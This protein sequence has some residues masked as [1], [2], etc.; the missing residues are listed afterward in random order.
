MLR[1]L[2]GGAGWEEAGDIKRTQP[3]QKEREE[4]SLPSRPPPRILRF[5][6]LAASQ[7]TIY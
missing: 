5:L 3:D 2:L 6:W 4:P 1:W 7:G